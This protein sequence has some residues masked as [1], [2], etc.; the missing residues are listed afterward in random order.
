M[1]RAAASLERL[2]VKTKEALGANLLRQVTRSPVPTHGFWALTRIGARALFYGPLNLVVHPQVVEGWID[3]LLA[4]QPANDSE[5]NGWAF[6]LANLARLTGQR[7]LD[8]DEA[9]RARALDALR[10]LKVPAHW[11]EMVERVVAMDAADR[12]QMF[13][14]SLP[15]G[16]RLVG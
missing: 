12:G 1:W 3:Q 13:G 6:C 16:L 2:D 8:V 11:V 14:E 7:A 15:I 9:V 4:F 10:P 5:K